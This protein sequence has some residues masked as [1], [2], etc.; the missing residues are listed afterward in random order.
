[1]N[2]INTSLAVRATATADVDTP[3]PAAADVAAQQAAYQP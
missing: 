1:M 2:T 3:S